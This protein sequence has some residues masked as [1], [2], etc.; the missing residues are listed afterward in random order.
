MVSPSAHPTQPLISRNLNSLQTR[1]P[2]FR[3]LDHREV[4]FVPLSGRLSRNVEA[5]LFAED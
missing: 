1:Q 2:Q 5:V 3:F 4:V